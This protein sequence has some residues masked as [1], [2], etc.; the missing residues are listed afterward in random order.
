MLLK[1]ILMS[2]NGVVPTTRLAACAK[3]Q[4]Q[5]VHLASFEQ[6]N[7]SWVALEK[8]SDLLF[9][10]DKPERQNKS[11]Q[12]QVRN[13]NRTFVNLLLNMGRDALL[14]DKLHNVLN[15]LRNLY[16][17]NLLHHSLLDA[18]LWDDLHKPGLH[19]TALGVCTSRKKGTG[20]CF[21]HP[22]PASSEVCSLVHAGTSPSHPGAGKSVCLELGRLHRGDST[23]MFFR[24]SMTFSTGVPL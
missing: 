24:S 16:I 3:I 18:R 10:S 6:R 15:N 14:R 21:S 11:V 20:T 9:A 2:G 12:K 7:W 13:W 19:C 1:S 23:G 22:R 4:F 17:L 5:V 8:H